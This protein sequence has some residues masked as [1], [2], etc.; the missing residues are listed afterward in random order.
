ME[1]MTELLKAM[2]EMMEMQ[3]G[4]LISRMDIHQA[5]TEAIQEEIIAK[6]DAHHER[7]GASVNACQKETT[8][9]KEATES[10]EPTSAEILESVAE[11]EEV[12]REEAAVKTVRAQK[13]GYG[14]RHLAERR[15]DQS[16]KQT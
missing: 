3:M 12:P 14:D 10:K 4:T 13:E 16:K 8:A 5:R 15:L 1:P 9:C 2:Q 6:M 7:M 11:N